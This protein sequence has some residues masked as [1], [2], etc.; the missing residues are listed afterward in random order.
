MAVC[1][2]FFGIPK[3]NLA[4]SPKQTFHPSLRLEGFKDA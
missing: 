4:P 2:T 1:P 3:D